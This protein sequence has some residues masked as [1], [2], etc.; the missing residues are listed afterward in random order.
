MPRCQGDS[1]VDKLHPAFWRD[2]L[3]LLF[4]RFER[5][6]GSLLLPQVSKFRDHR[7]VQGHGF[8]NNEMAGKSNVM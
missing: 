5:R 6:W 8:F 4:W 3:I 1:I 2:E 7:G